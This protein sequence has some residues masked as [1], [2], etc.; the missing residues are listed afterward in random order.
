MSGTGS[1][2]KLNG[3]TLI[4]TGPNTYSG[5]TIVS[6]G[7]LQGNTISVQGNITNNATVLFDQAADGTYAG[8]MSGTGALRKQGAGTLTLAANNTYT[9]A[10]TISAGRLDVNGAVA[11]AVT[12]QNA[13]TLGGTGQVGSINNSGRLAPGNS[14]GTLTVNG[15]Y[16][17]NSGATLEVEVDPVGLSDLIHVSGTATLNG[18]TV[19]VIAL[20]GSFTA[21]TMY[22]I[23]TAA[24]GVNGTFATVT[25]DFA[26][27]NPEI[28]Y[29]PNDVRLLL[30]RNQSSFASVA[31]TFNQR[32]AAGA[33][34]ALSVYATGDMGYVIDTIVIMSAPAARSAFDQI[35][36][37]IYGSLAAVEL[38]NTTRWLSLIADRVRYMHSRRAQ[39]GRARDFVSATAP[40][41]P[42]A[43]APPA[44]RFASHSRSETSPWPEL[45]DYGWRGDPTWHAWTTGYGA[46][47][48]VDGD[49]NATALDY[50]FAGTIVGIDRLLDENAIAGVT[51]GFSPFGVHRNGGRDQ[52]EADSYSVNLYGNQ[53]FGP[54]YALGVVGYAHETIDATRRIAFGTI[55]R[56]AQADFTGDVFA[57]YVETGLTG[58]WDDHVA[59]P[60][61]GMQYVHVHHDDFAETGADA[62]NLALA[63]NGFDSLR[64]ALGGRLATTI[65]TERGWKFVPDARLRWM[66][67]LLDETGVIAPRFLVGGASFP[68]HGGRLGRDYFVLGAGLNVHFIDRVSLFGGYDAQISGNESGHGGNVGIQVAW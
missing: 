5:G 52:I 56:T 45:W 63:D 8:V 40:D 34:D 58:C 2:T 27:V 13:G 41:A 51:L 48:D 17:H 53:N 18:G 66:H 20:P 64:L 38:E 57:L 16:T 30:V 10:T 15:N 4:L 29:G 68:V 14:I 22:T 37:E 59:Q 3:G 32:S 67:E 47:G 61:I 55:D 62:L 12:I 19:E 49:G 24:G 35:N 60:L 42:D 36:C 31:A 65:F 7:T 1:L 46:A 6:A 11:G 43:P 39:V 9:G 44:M 50:Y 54:H 28:H 26:F 25:H 21:G 33:L 23:L